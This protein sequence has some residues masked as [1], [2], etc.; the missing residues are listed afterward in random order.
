MKV[1]KTGTRGAALALVVIFGLVLSILAAAVFTL[2]KSNTASHLYVRDRIQARYSAE[3]GVNLAVHMILGGASVPADTFPVQFL[4][5]PPATGYYDMPG[6]DLGEV[7]VVVDPSDAN[8]QIA[9][10]NAYGVRA[11]S[12]VGHA[13]TTYTY[14]METMVLPENFAR[15][16]T[17]LGDPPLNGYYGDGYRFDGP[18]FANGPVCLWS[19]SAT[20]TNDIW[21]YR[22]S[23]ASDYY[24]YGTSGPG[25][26]ATTP[27]YGNLTIQPPERM[28]LGEPYFELGVDPIPFGPDEVNWQDARDAAIAGGLYF[29]PG[30]LPSNARLILKGDSLSLADTLLVKVN[31]GAAVQRHV[32][33][34][35]SNPVIWI[36]NNAADNIYLKSMPPYSPWSDPIN[37]QGLNMPLTIG[38]NG[39]IYAYGPL[40]Y[41]DRDLLDPHNTTMLGLI[42]VYGDF[43]MAHDPQNTGGTDW[44]DAIWQ[45][46]TNG[47][48]EYDCTMMVLSGEFVAQNYQYPQPIKDFMIVGG[49]IVYSEG[50]TTWGNIGGYDTVIYY[51][52]RLMSMHPP[53]FPQTG[54]WDTAYWE[55]LPELSELTI[56]MNRY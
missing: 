33:T 30:V 35:L 43:V 6:D 49:Y 17:F 4:P 56:F 53:F 11:L 26:Q 22:F 10:A 20:T 31:S 16:A 7:I 44:P 32:L 13:D 14:G 21:F 2:F 8:A 51:D 38:C 28:L 55:E 23:L 29:G 50:Y 42:I 54:R 19:S 1:S 40:Q 39:S 27:V 47:D 25:I 34:G 45:I 9:T 52:T 46:V 36:D 37:P 5:E 15:F 12:R 48:V 24:I 3:A 41:H 18:F